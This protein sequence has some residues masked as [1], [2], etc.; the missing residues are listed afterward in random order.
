[1]DA[2]DDF[3]IAC[4]PFVMRHPNASA[5]NFNLQNAV[6][7]RVIIFAV[8]ENLFDTL[9]MVFWNDVIHID[10]AVI[11]NRRKRGFWADHLRNGDIQNNAGEIVK[12]DVQCM[13]SGIE[14]TF[15]SREDFG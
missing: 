7:K 6:P 15:L 3:D 2:T 4:K 1:M 8:S 11:N 13:Q 9:R 14:D 10:C 5:S 12:R